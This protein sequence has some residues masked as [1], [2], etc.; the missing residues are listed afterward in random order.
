VFQSRRRVN[1]GGPQQKAILALLLLRNGQQ[2]SIHEICQNL[3]GANLPSAASGT[4]RTHVYRLR[5]AL[6]DPQEGVCPIDSL[7]GGYR[8]TL[9]P[10]ELDLN[11]FH[12]DVRRSRAARAAGNHEVARQLLHRALSLWRGK[13]FTGASGEFLAHE[14]AHLEDLR[15]IT[16][17]ERI[18]LDLELGRHGAL[19]PELTRLTSAFPLRERFWEL[20]MLALHGSGRQAEALA[21]YQKVRQIL[22]REFGIEPGAELRAAH[23]EILAESRPVRQG[24]ATARERRQVAKVG[25]KILS[26][27]AKSMVPEQLPASNPEF[28]GRRKE[29]DRILS[30][31][32]AKDGPKL[33][34]ITGLPGVGKTELAVYAANRLRAEFPDGQLYIDLGGRRGQAAEPYGVLRSLFPAVDPG[35]RAVPANLA[36]ATALWRTLL[37]DKRMLIIVDDVVS[38]HQVDSLVPS[39]RGCAVIATSARWIR[40]GSNIRW[41]LLSPLV[42]EEASGLLAN[43]IGP[44]RCARESLACAEIVRVCSAIPYALQVVAERIR[45]K[46]GW[47]ISETLRQIKEGLAPDV[48][49]IPVDAELISGP[50]LKAFSR[51][52]CDTGCSVSPVPARG[53]PSVATRSPD[54]SPRPGP[55]RRRFSTISLMHISSRLCRVAPM[56][57]GTWFAWSGDGSRTW[58][59]IAASRTR[60]LVRVLFGRAG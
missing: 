12:R 59:S 26:Y 11:L 42:D 1:V 24:S 46:P 47:P 39:A 22:N 9:Q 15:L 35:I 7:T 33:V 21:A 32:S 14:R 43:L 19:L 10:E 5:S 23:R 34:G 56:S 48:E 45:S 27:A 38:A 41:Q 60:R 58:R 2:I 13:A 6:S 25:P 16:V 36:G 30:V 53:G 20:L 18:W 37:R 40:G 54:Y 50:I 4:V 31:L 3:W 52:D 8:L 44:D 17:E 29:L 51:L 28:V 49:R 55:R 57:T